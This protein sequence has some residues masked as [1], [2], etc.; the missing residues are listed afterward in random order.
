V[1]HKEL[2]ALVTESQKAFHDLKAA[3]DKR[4]S[5]VKEFGSF[6]SE[7]LL[8]IERINKHLDEID[9][10][11]AKKTPT[12]KERERGEEMTV[13]MKAMDKYVRY[14]RKGL[15]DGRFTDEEKSVFDQISKKSLATNDD[16]KGGIIVPEDFQLSIIKKVPNFSQVAGLVRTQPTSRDVLRWPTIPYSTDDISTSGVS[17]TWE[18]ETDTNTETD[19]S[20]GSS[21]VGIKKCRA[22]IKVSNDLL[23]DNAV[24]IVGLLSDLL[25]EAFGIESDKVLTNGSGGKK[26]EGFM[27]NSDIS[28]INSGAGA[29]LTYDGLVN[30]IYGLPEQYSQGA[31]FMCKRATVA[32]L[33]Q[34]KDSQNRPL[35]EPSMQVG[36]PATVLGMPIRTNEHMPAVAAA[37]KAA[38]V[39]DFNR[40]YVLAERVGLTIRRLDEKY[41]DTD[42]VGFIARRRFGGKVVAPWA[43]RTLTIAA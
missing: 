13:E 25:A 3:L 17:V 18:D 1:E 22:L 33:R 37:A 5:E 16:T 28:T 43:A 40:L 19:F 10:K 20:M 4:D 41:A 34:L 21:A 6:R 30:F 27:T 11:L 35:W 15:H 31:V 8:T 39:A 32:L 2:A 24:D 38:V 42:E 14:G 26:P 12:A 23:E 29:A 36:A 7:T 9:V